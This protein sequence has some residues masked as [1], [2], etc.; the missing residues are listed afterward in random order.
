[1]LQLLLNLLQPVEPVPDPAPAHKRTTP[2]VH[3]VDTVQDNTVPIAT[4][5]IEPDAVYAADTA[6]GIADACHADPVFAD[7]DCTKKRT[8]LTSCSGSKTRFCF[9]L[10]L[11]SRG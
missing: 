1:M 7:D 9:L 11:E 4:E 8:S 2:T 5:D 10:I 3:P 6:S